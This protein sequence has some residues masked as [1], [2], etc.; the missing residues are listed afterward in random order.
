[1]KA[2]KR[3]RRGLAFLLAFALVF[4]TFVSDL[5]V[6]NAQENANTESSE[7]EAS[8]ET[9]DKPEKEEKKQEPEKKETPKK[10]ENKADDKKPAKETKPEEPEKAEETKKDSEPAKAETE[11]KDN[12]SE[13]ADAKTD[14]NKAEEPKADSPSK[15]EAKEDN[16]DDA[17]EKAEKYTV[18]FKV[19]NSDAGVITVA[20]SSVNAASYKKDVEEGKDFKFS[21]TAKEGFD[22]ESVKANG[23]NAEKSGETGYAV[24]NVKKDTEIAVQYKE[25]P[26]AEIVKNLE[27]DK[28]V[29]EEEKKAL[30]EVPQETMVMSRAKAVSTGYI[31]IKVRIYDTSTWKSYDVGTDKVSTGNPGLIQSVSYRIPQLSY[32]VDSSKFG[33]VTKVVGNWYFPPGDQQPGMSVEW[34]TNVS[35]V[36]MTYWVDRYN[37]SGAL[38]HLW[39]FTLNYDAKGGTGAPLPQTYGTNSSY[40]KSHDFTIRS[41]KP[42]REGYEFL[43]W[44]ENS[45]ATSVTHKPGGNYHM[46]Q[47]V[48]HYNGGSVSKTLY[49]VWKETPADV[50]LTYKDRGNVYK[51]STH[52]KGTEVTIETCE[53]ERPGYVFKGWATDSRAESVKFAANDIMMLNENTTLYAVW[54]KVSTY[55]VYW[56]DIEG[57]PIKFPES[58]EGVIGEIVSVTPQDKNMPNYIFDDG[59]Q[60]N[61]VSAMLSAS[62]TELRLYFKKAKAEPNAEFTLIKK[63]EGLDEIPSAFSINP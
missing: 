35:S 57:E 32:F 14:E 45:A 34:S 5:S 41:D 11:V 44:S 1:M 63:F 40:E 7:G 49:A 39:N 33:K 38:S 12:G 47:T 24:R 48:S 2:R 29:T 26:E 28:E 61:R 36:T 4:T 25:T 8:K 9:A 56:Y 27:T 19:N 13:S 43:G 16:K 51:E 46:V 60:G 53:N 59:N 31:T 50:T 21:V 30:E 42:E 58:R 52:T 37:P 54:K 18:R 6:V 55:R 23:A 10:E 17:K 15:E 3:G 22:V 62:G 20:G